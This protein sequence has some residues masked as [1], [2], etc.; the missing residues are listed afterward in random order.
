VVPG[1]RLCLRLPSE[2]LHLFDAGTGLRLDM[3]A[4]TPEE[5]LETA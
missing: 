1:G 5:L 4:T 3:P 2:A